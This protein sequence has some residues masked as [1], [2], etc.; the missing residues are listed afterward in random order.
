V[1]FERWGNGAAALFFLFIKNA[2]FFAYTLIFTTFI[3]IE[4]EQ[5]SCFSPT[6][7]TFKIRTPPWLYPFIQSPK[8]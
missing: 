3:A 1:N 5:T 7:Q 2:V 6:L 4:T 8:I